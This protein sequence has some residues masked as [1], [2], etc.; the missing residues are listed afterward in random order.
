MKPLNFFSSMS[1][2]MTISFGVI[3]II[4]FCGAIFFGS[5][6]HY[7]FGSVALILCIVNGIDNTF[8]RNAFEILNDFIVKCIDIFWILLKTFAKCIF[9]VIVSICVLVTYAHVY[10][11]RL[12]Y[13]IKNNLK[14]GTRK[15][16]L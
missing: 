9:F 8:D 3:A 11:L 10:T 4:C 13:H 12:Y 14:N 16:I 7:F 2:I 1:V 5:T 15:P 6:Q